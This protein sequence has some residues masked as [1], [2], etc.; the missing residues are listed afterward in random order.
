MYDSE[1]VGRR[2]IETA[3]EAEHRCAFGLARRFRCPGATS[4]PGNCQQWWSA[5]YSRAD[6]CWGVGMSEMCHTRKWPFLPS[7]PQDALAGIAAGDIGEFAL[8]GGSGRPA[9]KP[10]LFHGGSD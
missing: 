8:E 1:G 10:F 9:V 7:I 3:S 2:Q 4:A 5:C 6:I